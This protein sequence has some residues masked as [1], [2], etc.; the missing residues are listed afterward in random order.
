[1]DNYYHLKPTF[2]KIDAEG[3]EIE[4]LKE[5]SRIMKTKPMFAIEVHIKEHKSLGQSPKDLLD[6]IDSNS[7]KIF[8]QPN[9]KTAPYIR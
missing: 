6:L 9:G 4:I 7:Y 2:L 1:L 3:Y 5:A 8:L